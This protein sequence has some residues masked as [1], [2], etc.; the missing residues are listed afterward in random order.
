MKLGVLF[1]GGKDSTFAMYKAMEEKGNEQNNEVACLIT[2]ISKNSDSYMFHT[3]N[4]S[5]TKLQA[6]AIGLPFIEQKTLGEKEKE[7]FDLKKAI[8]KAKDK[9]KIEGIVSGAFASKYQ[10][11]RIERICSELKLKSITPLWGEDPEKMMREM[12]TKGFRFLLSSIAALGLDESWLGRVLTDKDIDKLVV[13]NKKVGIHIAFEGG[14]A[15]SLMIE[16]P[17]FKKKIIIKEA[18]KI[19]ENENTGVYL[20]TRAELE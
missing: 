15:E 7:L 11:E 19:M 1:S 12:I 3:P 5:L 18:K 9:Y 6:E 8:K 14:E 20:I 16:G 2:L 10:K 17:V 13:L 4:I